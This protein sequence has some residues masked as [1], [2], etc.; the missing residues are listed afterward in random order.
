M[1][2]SH[3]IDRLSST[4]YHSMILLAQG[5]MIWHAILHLYSKE[6]IQ[7]LDNFLG[8][9]K[10]WNSNLWSIRTKDQVYYTHHKGGCWCGITEKSKA[11]FT[12]KTCVKHGY[13]SQSYKWALQCYFLKRMIVITRIGLHIITCCMSCVMNFVVF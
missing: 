13:K 12:K 9:K 6:R 11:F 4:L 5:D 2:I 3:F 1:I 8:S 7:V 10:L